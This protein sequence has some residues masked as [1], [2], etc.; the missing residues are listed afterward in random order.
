MALIDSVAPA[1]K[2]WVFTEF[3]WAPPKGQPMM[4]AGDHW[5]QKSNQIKAETAKEEEKSRF[6]LRSSFRSF[7]FTFVLHERR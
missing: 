6:R 2:Y 3:P 4:V 5:R 7:F 1:L